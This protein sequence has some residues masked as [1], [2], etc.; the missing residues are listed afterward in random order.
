MNPRDD[1]TSRIKTLAEECGFA[2]AGVAP[3]E[4]VKQAEL[5][6]VWL[7]SGYHADMTYLA[8]NVEIRMN[9]AALLEGARSILCLVASYPAGGETARGA[10]QIARYARGRDYHAVLKKRA[11]TLCERIRVLEPSFVG[12][13]FVDTAPIA[14]RS[15]AASAGLGWIGRNGSLIVPGLGSYVLLAEIVCNLPLRLDSPCPSGC[16]DCTQCRAACPTGAFV[17][18]GLLDARRCLSYQTIENR[19]HIPEE[20]WPLTGQCVFGCDACQDI[21][22][23]NRRLRENLPPQEPSD[24]PVLAIGDILAWKED[25]WDRFTRGRTLRRAS[26][27]MWQRNAILAAGH[28]GDSSLLPLLEALESEE[29]LRPYVAWAR[30]RILAT[31]SRF[32]RESRGVAGEEK[33]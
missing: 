22:P 11:R 1:L 14:E 16:G 4:P 12:R 10:V 26:R 27:R 23:H 29:F 9:P 31:T 24:A 18:E 7:E 6:R 3:A 8:R 20:L 5:F 25:D 28:S 21:C 2:R 15:L 19:G 17:S 13:I 30:Q 32:E 33:V